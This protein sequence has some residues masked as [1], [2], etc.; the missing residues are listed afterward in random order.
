MR[1]SEEKAR[2]VRKEADSKEETAKEA[3]TAEKSY[4]YQ[5]KQ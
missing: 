3:A 5:T 4:S 2:G 1:E